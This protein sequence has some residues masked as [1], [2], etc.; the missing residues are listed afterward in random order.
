MVA[1][2]E[3]IG[4]IPTE[5]RPS[6]P[7][8][9]GD[10]TI[11]RYPPVPLAVIP[12]L[13]VPTRFCIFDSAEKSFSNNNRCGVYYIQKNHLLWLRRGL[14]RGELNTTVHVPHPPN[15]IPHAGSTAF[16]ARGRILPNDITGMLDIRTG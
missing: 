3:A 9:V 15:H 14:A 7:V 10:F 5:N 11:D 1:D 16:L 13:P 6:K 8:R 2:T 4:N 12:T